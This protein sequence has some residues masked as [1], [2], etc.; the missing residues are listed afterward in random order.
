LGLASVKG[1]GG[2]IEG[3]GGSGNFSFSE[4]VFRV[5]FN[6]LFL[7]QSVVVGLFFGDG[8]NEFIEKGSDGI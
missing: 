3:S 2:F 5:T 4:S 6:L 1:F 8:G 7:P